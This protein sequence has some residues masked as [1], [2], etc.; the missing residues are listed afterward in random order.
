[1]SLLTW[2]CT[3]GESF[4]IYPFLAAL[5]AFWFDRAGG[6]GSSLDE[7]D[8]GIDEG[9]SRLLGVRQGQ[10]T[11]TATCDTALALLQLEKKL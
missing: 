11:A 3:S 1:M 8:D 7:D 9:F 10:T 6:H 2:D 5:V 4:N